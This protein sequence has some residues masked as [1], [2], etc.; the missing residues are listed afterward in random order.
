[1]IN[2]KIQE[3]S[4]SKKSWNLIKL[5]NNAHSQI[6]LLSKHIKRKNKHPQRPIIT[7][8]RNSGEVSIMECPWTEIIS[9]GKYI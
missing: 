9:N 8:A 6:L 2:N 1:M 4:Y 7:V 5:R 3:G